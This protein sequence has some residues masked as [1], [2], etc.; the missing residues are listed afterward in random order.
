MELGIGVLVGVLLGGLIT[1]LV[2]KARSASITVRLQE[3]E[4]SALRVTTELKQLSAEHSDLRAKYAGEIAAREQER[5]AAEEKLV[6]LREAQ[7][8][9]LIQ[10]QALSRKALDSNNKSFL[11][12]AKTQVE[13]LLTK[14]DAKEEKR[15]L[16]MKNLV[17][18]L[19]KSLKEVT[20]QIGDIEKQRVNAYSSLKEQVKGLQEAQLQ[21]QKE[22]HNLVTALRKPTVRGQWGEFH[23]RRV[24]E[25]AGLVEHC[26]FDEQHTVRTDD[27]LLRPDLVV[28]LAGERNIVVDA[29]TPLDAYLSGVE[30]EDADKKAAFFTQHVRQVRDHVKNLASKSY[31]TQFDMAPEMV[32]LFLP[33][34]SMLYEAS[35]ADPTLLEYGIRNRVLIATPMTLI[36]LLHGV[37]SG[38]RQDLIV[39]NAQQISRLGQDLYERICKMAEHFS[40]VGSR[41][42]S[43]VSSYNS[44]V[45]SLERRVLV[46][47]RRFKEMG[48][49]STQ[50]VQE[51]EQVD[52]AAKQ[53]EAGDFSNSAKEEIPLFEEGS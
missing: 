46:S 9:L 21:I 10:F 43:A 19:E 6:L 29:K 32:V 25:L 26:D 1:W 17:D 41:L 44:A 50:D 38:W 51:I 39:Q 14:V 15:T 3:K 5:L 40:K 16:E 48:A 12:L 34:E 31:H 35:H 11:E 53:L 42:N 37:A 7:E 47:A 24:V 28:H 52:T 33:A 30:E 45:G 13:H 2:S 27:G 49:G 4:E 22:A 23:L 18:P 36:A 8:E 20:K